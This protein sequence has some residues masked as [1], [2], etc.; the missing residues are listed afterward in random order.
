M[1]APVNDSIILDSLCANMIG[2]W[3]R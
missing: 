3:W 2:K 1:G